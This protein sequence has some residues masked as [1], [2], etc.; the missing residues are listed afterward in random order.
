MNELLV[1]VTFS[2][3]LLQK[4]INLHGEGGGKDGKRG[5]RVRG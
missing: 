5:K 2:C 4:L 3:S 1:A